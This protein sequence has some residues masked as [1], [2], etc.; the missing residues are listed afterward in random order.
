[1][2]PYRV[3]VEVTTKWTLEVYGEDEQEAEDRAQNMDLDEIE[4]SGDFDEIT[5]V[6]VTDVQQAGVWEGGQ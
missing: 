2:K 1:M 6:E 4:S 5:N 3:Q